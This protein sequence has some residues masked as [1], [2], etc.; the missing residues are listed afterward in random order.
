MQKYH[1]IADFHLRKNPYPKTE[2][3]HR[4]LIS[5]RVRRVASCASKILPALSALEIEPSFSEHRRDAKNGS[6]I[7]ADAG[8]GCLVE[9]ESQKD[10]FFIVLL[11]IVLAR[12]RKS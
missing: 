7:S 4:Y 5:K 10:A 8:G 9:I 3:I 6:K 2:A 11:F 1:K 12:N